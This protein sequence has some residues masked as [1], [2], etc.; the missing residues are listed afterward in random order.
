MSRDYTEADRTILEAIRGFEGIP[1]AK[2]LSRLVDVPFSNDLIQDRINSNPI[3]KQA[4]E[5]VALEY[6]NGLELAELAKKSAREDSLLNESRYH[7]LV[8][9]RIYERLD[10]FLLSEIQNFE[11]IPTSKALARSPEVQLSGEHIQR[12]I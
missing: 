12:R 1:T 7:P 11:G 4:Q 9:K 2:A 3:L 5:R 6:V 8:H 10:E